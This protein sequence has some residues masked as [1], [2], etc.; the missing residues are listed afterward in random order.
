VTCKSLLATACSCLGQGSS[1]SSLKKFLYKT[2]QCNIPVDSHFQNV[3][4]VLLSV[5]SVKIS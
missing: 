2:L 5:L 1:V 4:N 3:I